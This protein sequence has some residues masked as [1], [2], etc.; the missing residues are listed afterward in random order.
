MQNKTIITG[1][2]SMVIGFVAAMTMITQAYGA[3]C[4]RDYAA[5]LDGAVRATVSAVRGNDSG[6][7]LNQMS[8]D[9]VNFGSAGGTASYSALTSQFSQRTGRY[10]DLFSCNGRQGNLHHLFKS[11]QTDQSIDTKHALA[12]VTINANTNDELDLNY[13]FTTSCRWELSGISG[14]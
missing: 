8:R 2:T 1:A 3:T 5:S 9:G 4:S 12:N 14:T 6:A 10:C 11:G 13:R 7:L